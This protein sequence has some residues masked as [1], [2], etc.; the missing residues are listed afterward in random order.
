M[1]SSGLN[2]YSGWHLNRFLLE[3]MRLVDVVTGEISNHTHLVYIALAVDLQKQS[4]C[5]DF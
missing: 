2:T 3:N 4:C 5:C 1:K